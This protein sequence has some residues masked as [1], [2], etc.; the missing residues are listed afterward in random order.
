M[1]EEKEK[2]ATNKLKHAYLTIAWSLERWNTIW[3]LD[4]KKYF[5]LWR[6]KSSTCNHVM[7]SDAVNK[8]TLRGLDFNMYHRLWLCNIASKFSEQALS[9]CGIISGITFTALVLIMQQAD[10]F[11]LPFDV[12]E[13]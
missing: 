12:K 7:Q 10:A 11:A 2:D 9:A 8:F 5:S 1:I 4:D 6:S 13:F 3:L